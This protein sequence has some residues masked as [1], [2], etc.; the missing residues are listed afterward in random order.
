MKSS[1]LLARNKDMI[2]LE[3]TLCQANSRHWKRRSG[4]SFI[5]RRTVS[6]PAGQ[7][8]AEMWLGRLYAN[9][10]R[11]NGRVEG[12]QQKI[13]QQE[14]NP[15]EQ[16][17]RVTDLTRI[18]QCEVNLRRDIKKQLSS[19]KSTAALVRQVEYLLRGEKDNATLHLMN[20]RS[21][22]YTQVHSL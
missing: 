6:A 21:S 14:E 4:N 2:E 16:P 9:I 5:L 11:N 12:P 22:R 19:G 8:Q 10:G 7:N 20:N 17:V 1:I 13:E 18:P 15:N 3:R